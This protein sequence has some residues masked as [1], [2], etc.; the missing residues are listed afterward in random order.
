M[1]GAASRDEK[2]TRMFFD[3]REL[4]DHEVGCGIATDARL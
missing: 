1:V 2:K 4:P 3:R